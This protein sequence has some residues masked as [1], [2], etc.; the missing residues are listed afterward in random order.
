[1]FLSFAF[2]IVCCQLSSFNSVVYFPGLA[3]TAFHFGKCSCIFLARMPHFCKS[4]WPSLLL[5]G[6][7]LLHETRTCSV[8][9]QMNAWHEINWWLKLM[10][11][12]KSHK[13]YHINLNLFILAAQNLVASNTLVV[14]ACNLASSFQLIMARLYRTAPWRRLD[15][16]SSLKEVMGCRDKRGRLS[17]SIDSAGQASM[18]SHEVQGTHWTPCRFHPSALSCLLNASL[19]RPGVSCG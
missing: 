1:M 10:T 14:L 4:T 2:W 13:L 19:M 5:L 6:Y 18:M 9:L 15:S 12:S 8:R 16:R 7:H 17:S 3:K 11:K